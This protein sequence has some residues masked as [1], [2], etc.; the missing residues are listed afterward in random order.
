M[1]LIFESIIEIS[2][3]EYKNLF[4]FNFSQLS[5]IN[6]NSPYADS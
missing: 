5:K 4:D 2:T 1:S 6:L 3:H